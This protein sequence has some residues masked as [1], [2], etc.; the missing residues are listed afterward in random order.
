MLLLTGL[1][2]A[3]IAVEHIDVASMT[4]S[5]QNA[6]LCDEECTSAVAAGVSLMLSAKTHIKIS[7]LQVTLVYSPCLL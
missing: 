5:L 4:H 1:R 7:Q 2:I 3:S 6:G